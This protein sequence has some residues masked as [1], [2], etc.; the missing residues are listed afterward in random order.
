MKKNTARSIGF[1]LLFLLLTARAYPGECST[2]RQVEP[3]QNTDT[4][5]MVSPDY[6]GFNAETAGSNVFQNQMDDVEQVR[7]Q[8]LQEFGD[9]TQKL[10]DAGVRVI[11]LPSR[12][13]VVTPDAVFPNNWFSV[14]KK[15]DGERVLVL[16]PMMAPNRQ[17]ERQ[18][19]LLKT[20][21]TDQGF[22]VDKVTDLTGHEKSGHYLEGTGSMVLDRVHGVAFAVLSP[23]SSLEVLEDFGKR[24]GYKIVSFH[25]QD[26]NGSDIYH[27]NV[28][29]S[30]AGEFAVV[31]L[32]S[33]KDELERKK[34]V[35]ELHRLGKKIIPIT[36]EQIYHMCGNVI[37]LNTADNSKV[38]LLS[39][40]A[41]DAFTPEQKAA[42]SEY[43]TLLPVS[44]PTI[45]KIGGGSA[46]CMVGEVF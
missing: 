45:E 25:S 42:L 29:M 46:R 5:L 3:V 39:K 8:A 35:D 13:D 33:I 23:R 26:K 36:L 15:S 7:Q 4:V 38:L 16:Y 11:I 1:L 31:C 41:Y 19:D 2:N 9:M 6:F 14:H 12:K 10:Q 27:T 22:A 37:E 43:C 18:V 34:V 17:A 28:M 21:I 20:K 44:I 32:E 24:M 30:V 40:T